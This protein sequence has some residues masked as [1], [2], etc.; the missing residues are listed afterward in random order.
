MYAKI[1]DHVDEQATEIATLK[2]RLRPSLS[3]SVLREEFSVQK[4]PQTRCYTVEVRNIGPD[5][6]GDCLIEVAYFKDSSG[7]RLD[8]N[9]LVAERDHGGRTLKLRQETEKRFALSPGQARTVFIARLN[10]ENPGDEI[11]VRA[12]GGSTVRIGRDETYLVTL[13]AYGGPAPARA[14]YRMWVSQDG[15]LT[16]RAA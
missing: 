4:V 13:T 12:V 8:L 16:V 11:S 6:I 7:E 5:H 2:S 1:L 15:R 3:I 10:E 9:V 14:T